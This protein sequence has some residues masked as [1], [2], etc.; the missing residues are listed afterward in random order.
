MN[1]VTSGAFTESDFRIITD[2]L[3]LLS[4]LGVAVLMLLAWREHSNQAA[5][6]RAVRVELLPSHPATRLA[7]TG[8]SLHPWEYPCA[9]HGA[10]RAPPPHHPLVLQSDSLQTSPGVAAPAD[11]SDQP[12]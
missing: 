5:R 2:V 8:A 6:R 12:A 9:R 11:G 1:V 7:Q 10:T 4:A 3:M